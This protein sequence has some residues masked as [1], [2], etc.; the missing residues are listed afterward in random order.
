MLKKWLKLLTIE[1]WRAI[2]A[3]H[4]IAPLPSAHAVAIL[5]TAAIA[6]ILPRYFGGAEF[7]KSSAQLSALFVGLPH[8]DLYPRLYWSAFKLINWGILPALCIK[9]VLKQRLADHGLRLVS[10]PKVWLLYAGMLL[11]VLPMAYAAS[12]TDTFM[13]TYPKYHSA[14]DSWTQFFAW[15]LAYGFQFLMLEFFFRGF[16][17][18]ALARYVGSLAIFVMIVPYAMIHFGKPF[19]ECLASIFAGIALGTVALRTGSIYGGVA[20]HCGVAWSMDLFALS[21]SGALAR[22]LAR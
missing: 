22:L 11:L 17:I 6:L 18:F 20:V 2:D 7:F 15:E 16:L 10:E 8:P 14:G 3:Q 5:V 1:Q 19:A 13:S 21:Q 4:R 12:L 9:L